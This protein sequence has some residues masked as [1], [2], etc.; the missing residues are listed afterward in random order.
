MH[1]AL[2]RFSLLGVGILVLG[3]LVGCATTPNDRRPVPLDVVQ[4]QRDAGFDL[5]IPALP[6]DFTLIHVS[7]GE[8]PPDSGILSKSVSLGYEGDNGTIS[9]TQ[10]RVALGKP[11]EDIQ[12]P[13][14]RPIQIG[15][16]LFPMRALLVA[17]TPVRTIYYHR[18]PLIFLVSTGI[19][20]D[21]LPD[22]EFAAIVESLQPIGQ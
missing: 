20:S 15:N 8:T 7:M 10:Y 6:D 18:G 12:G 22:A 21:D 5:H 17:G 19:S 3:L 9:L 2:R 13:D 11:P 14:V 4:A 16:A 1:C